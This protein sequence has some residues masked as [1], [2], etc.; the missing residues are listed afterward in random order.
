MELGSAE[1]FFQQYSLLKHYEKNL[2]HPVSNTIVF[3]GKCDWTRK[4]IKLLRNYDPINTTLLHPLNL[5]FL[6]SFK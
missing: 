4:D 1:Y 5:D 3:F 6:P 2:S